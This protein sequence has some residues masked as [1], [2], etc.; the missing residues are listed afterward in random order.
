[1][2]NIY[3]ITGNGEG[4]T[5]L[6]LGMGVRSLGHGHD[7]ALI[8]F[9]K[10]K[11]SGECKFGIERFGTWVPIGVSNRWKSRDELDVKFW[12]HM[13]EDSLLL[14]KHLVESRST[15]R[16]LINYD[17]LVL[18]EAW[19]I[20]DIDTVCKT[21]ESIKKEYPYVNQVVTGRYASESM[22]NL[23]DFVMEINQKKSPKEMICVE[24]INF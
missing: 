21:L 15:L 18:A 17:E 1:M 11:D 6:A 8:R 5:R 19:G 9:L 3:V 20:I 4:K 10:W 22:E 16:L 24:G 12:R 14:A 7:V 23:A 13:S 2:G